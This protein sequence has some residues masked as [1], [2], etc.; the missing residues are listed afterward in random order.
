MP[1]QEF[2]NNWDTQLKPATNSMAVSTQKQD[3]SL[4]FEVVGK[5]GNFEIAKANIDVDVVDLG[6]LFDF[7]VT[8]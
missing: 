5:M 7:Q 8:T 3:I 4:D 2:I 6:F 1:Q